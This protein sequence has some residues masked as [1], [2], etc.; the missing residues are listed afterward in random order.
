MNNIWKLINHTVTIYENLSEEMILARSYPMEPMTWSIIITYGH[1]AIGKQMSKPILTI[2]QFHAACNY[3]YPSFLP[4]S[5]FQWSNLEIVLQCLFI[6][7]THVY[8]S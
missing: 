8:F 3:H 2:T 5:K 6:I 1:W 7:H 4:S